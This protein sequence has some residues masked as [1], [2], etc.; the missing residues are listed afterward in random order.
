MKWINLVLVTRLNIFKNVNNVRYGVSQ[1][2]AENATVGRGISF[3]F[4]FQKNTMVLT[5]RRS[6][7]VV[8][9]PIIHEVEVCS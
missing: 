1:R 8:N 5:P 3:F 2:D 7:L 4:S 6:G 9:P